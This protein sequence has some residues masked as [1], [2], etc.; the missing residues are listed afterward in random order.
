MVN[1]ENYHSHDICGQSFKDLGY[2][3]SSKKITDATLYQILKCVRLRVE[4]IKK[5][6][7]EITIQMNKL[8]GI[9]KENELITNNLIINYKYK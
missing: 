2:S 6:N 7:T 5:H 8:G 4:C 3:I 9:K 1:C